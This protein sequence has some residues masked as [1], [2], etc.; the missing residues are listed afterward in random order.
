MN[1]STGDDVVQ[2]EIHERREVDEVLAVVTPDY[3]KDDEQAMDAWQHQVVGIAKQNCWRQYRIPPHDI[4]WVKFD[5][6]S[7]DDPEQAETFQPG[8]GCERCRAG[9]EKV[10][11]LL[12]TVPGSMVTLVN[13]Y[14]IEVW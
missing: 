1:H 6:L 8:D 4:E 9:N 14:Y 3:A 11:E 13:I 12:K 5:V 2:R 7:T 10:A